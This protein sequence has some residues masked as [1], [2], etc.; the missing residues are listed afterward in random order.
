MC[1]CAHMPVCVQVR[2]AQALHSGHPHA[3]VPLHPLSPEGGVPLLC[4]RKAFL[5][6]VVEIGHLDGVVGWLSRIV[7]P[8]V[9][10]TNAPIFKFYHQPIVSATG[11]ILPQSVLHLDYTK[12]CLVQVWGH[13]MRDLQCA[14]HRGTLLFTFFTFQISH[15]PSFKT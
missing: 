8:T 12:R 13:G 6:F 1:V 5:P 11:A 4:P 15:L 14:E 3:A 2:H 9:Q 10:Q 7:P